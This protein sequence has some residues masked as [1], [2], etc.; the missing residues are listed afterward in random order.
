MTIF[1]IITVKNKFIII[2][3]LVA[4]IGT[5]STVDFSS[6]FY[7]LAIKRFAFTEGLTSIFDSAVA[8][9]QFLNVSILF[10]LTSI[11]SILQLKYL[12]SQK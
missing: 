8:F 12:F 3:R 7:F 5:T 6:I 11:I 10:L 9:N 2:T 1:K 4:T